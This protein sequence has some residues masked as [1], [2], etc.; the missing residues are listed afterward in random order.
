MER[1]NKYVGVTSNC[2]DRKKII[3]IIKQNLQIM[4]SHIALEYQNQSCKQP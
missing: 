1:K 3:Y 4:L 2:V